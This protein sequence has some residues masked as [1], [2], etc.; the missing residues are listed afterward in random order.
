MPSST[1]DSTFFC[2][3]PEMFPTTITNNDPV[4]HSPISC[5]HVKHPKRY[6]DDANLFFN[7][8]GIL[9]SLHQHKFNDS[10][11]SRRLQHIEPCK[12]APIGTLPSLFIPIDNLSI[13]MFI[14]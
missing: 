2:S 11:F 6:F 14:T 10:H 5:Y 1:F 13:F 3:I 12:T 8:H 7:Q 4:Q 9:F